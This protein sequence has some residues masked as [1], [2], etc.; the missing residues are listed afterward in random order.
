MGFHYV[1]DTHAAMR[2]FVDVSAVEANTDRRSL[3]TYVSRATTFTADWL[4]YS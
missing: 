2:M 4:A 1:R 3:H